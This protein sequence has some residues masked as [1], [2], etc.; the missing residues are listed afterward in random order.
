MTEENKNVTV[1]EDN[2]ENEKTVW[3]KSQVF[4]ALYIV[5]TLLFIV[6]LFFVGLSLSNNDGKIMTPGPLET[7]STSV[8]LSDT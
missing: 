3:S 2:R 4:W 7:S 1:P 5:L 8:T 6:I